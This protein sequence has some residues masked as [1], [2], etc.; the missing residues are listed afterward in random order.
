MSGTRTRTGT[1]LRKWQDWSK[2]S[3]RVIEA[4]LV[5][6]A[7]NVTEQTVDRRGRRLS[8]APMMEWT[9]RH[10]RAFH[11]VFSKH[12]LLYT[13]ML[14]ANALLHGDPRR[15]LKHA[16]VEYPLALQ[17]GGSEPDKLAA[18]VGIARDFG[19]C[20]INLN[21]GCPSDRVQNGAFGAVLMRTP[22]LVA[23]CVEAMIGAAGQDG[24]EITV[25]C[26]I[27]VD[28]QDPEVVL[29]D[30]VDRIAKRGV[31]SFAVH[32]RKAWLQGLSPKDNRT[33]PPLD[34]D[35]VARL[36]ADRPDLEIVLNGGI[37]TL[38]QAVAHLDTFDGVMIGRAAYHDP[39]GILG[40]AD[41][42]V[43][44][45]ATRLPVDPVDAVRAMYPHIEAELSEGTRLHAITRHMLGA[46]NGRPGARR[47][48]R[49]L[50]EGA[51]LPGAGLELVER[52]LAEIIQQAA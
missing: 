6:M 15:W 16:P 38:D 37:E 11:R 14:T 3:A 45:D 51:H 29:P 18:A 2:P 47:W 26:R 36:K 31:R 5:D 42:R 41:R 7:K 12:A 4:T 24:P 19:F 39:A 43:F 33:I 46:F 13:E 34:H 8:V 27:G 52:A 10:C 28:E 21:C 30:F 50:S 35:L 1:L 22:D 23:D 25:K 40:E 48:R 44:G 17:L 49:M 9:D 20:E 32:A